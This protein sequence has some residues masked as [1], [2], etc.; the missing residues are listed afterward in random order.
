MNANQLVVRPLTVDDATAV[1]GLTE[2]LG[3]S[4]SPAQL[5]A[6]IESMVRSEDRVAFAALFD[7]ELLGWIDAAVERHLQADDTVVIGGLVVRET[8]RGRGVG[9]KLCEE[10]EHW[11][12]T[13]GFM[14]VRVRSQIKREDAHR[15]YLRDGYRQ[16]KTSLVFEKNLDC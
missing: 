16:V 14:K 1:T 9:K 13:R 7:T 8:A 11:A 10:V 12:R 5:R 15:F 4:G 6:R 3:Y 2:Q